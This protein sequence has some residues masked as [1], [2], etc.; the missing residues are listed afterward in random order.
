MILRRNVCRRDSRPRAEDF[1]TS[2]KPK[3]DDR[4]WVLTIGVLGQP[5]AESLDATLRLPYSRN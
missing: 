4:P 5:A 3:D 2:S 1:T